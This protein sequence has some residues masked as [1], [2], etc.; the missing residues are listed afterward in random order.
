MEAVKQGAAT[1]AVKSNTHVV[2]CALK[3]ASSLMPSIPFAPRCP[4][5]APHQNYPPTRRRSCS[6]TITSVSRSPASPPT[7]AFSGMRPSRAHPSCDLLLSSRFMRTECVNH[8]YGFDKPM[9]VT[10]LMDH[11]SNSTETVLVV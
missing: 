4:S 6:S 1:V 2:L 10:R 5:S 11:V 3:V 8:Q 7:V 9:P